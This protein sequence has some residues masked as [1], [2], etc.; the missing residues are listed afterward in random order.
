VKLLISEMQSLSRYVSREFYYTMTELVS[1]YGWKQIDTQE[2]WRR[3]GSLAS[4]L[5][6]QFGEMP[7]VILFWEGYG[8]RLA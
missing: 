8:F 7:S 2:L 1:A 3:P 5:Q 4:R 6:M